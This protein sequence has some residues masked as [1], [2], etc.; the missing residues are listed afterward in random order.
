MK[1]LVII[2]IAIIILAAVYLCSSQNIFSKFKDVGPFRQY[3]L[4]PVV[5]HP[6]YASN[7]IYSMPGTTADPYMLYGSGYMPFEGTVPAV[8]VLR[9]NN[10]KVLPAYYKQYL[11]Q[12]ITP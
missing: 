8:D 5:N 10:K 12:N 11:Q 9:A 6:L 7:S 4:D 2:L 1:T 3:Y